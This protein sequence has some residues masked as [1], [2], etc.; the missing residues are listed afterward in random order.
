MYEYSF[1]FHI[2]LKKL[3]KSFDQHFI[4]GHLLKQVFVFNLF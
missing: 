3:M 4:T 1:S 2:V